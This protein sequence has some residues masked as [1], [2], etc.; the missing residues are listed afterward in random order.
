MH[1]LRNILLI[2][3]ALLVQSTFYGRMDFLGIR[4]DLG[5][6]VLIFIASGS[7]TAE[8]VLYGFLIGFVQDVYSPEYLGYNSFTM[9]SIGFMLGIMRETLAV[10]K[11]AL[12][13][14]ITFLACLLHDIVYLSFYT[15][16]NFSLLVNLFL[17]ESIAGALYTSIL[18]FLF[19]AVYEWT[20]G[21]G[22]RIVVRKFIGVGK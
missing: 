5:M 3:L 20:A 15:A 1:R 6:L 13:T 22:P 17:K 10:E 4:P 9:S 16:L 8:S 21:G 19:I 2:V 12:K 11:Y 7:G 18:T 14:T